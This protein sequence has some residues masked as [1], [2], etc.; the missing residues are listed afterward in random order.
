LDPAGR[1][2]ELE[3]LTRSDDVAGRT[4]AMIQQDLEALGI[5]VSIRQQEMRAVIGR[6]MRARD[7]DTALMNM[8]FPIEPSDIMN[9]LS[10]SGNM[11]FWNP[12]QASPASEW[13][14]RIDDLMLLQGTLLDRDRRFEAFH[15]VQEIL[16]REVPFIPIVNRNIL[17]AWQPEIQN[18]RPASVF[19]YGLSEI[20]AVYLVP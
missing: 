15:E 20:W 19:P 10:S 11:H 5:A 17:V 14:A 18:L 2:V 1:A 8:D 13:E 4:A 9:V 16:A 12:L 7:Y 6:I 3:I